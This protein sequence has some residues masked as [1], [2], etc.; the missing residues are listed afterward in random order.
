MEEGRQALLR[1][2]SVPGAGCQVCPD[3]ALQELRLGTGTRSTSPWGHTCRCPRAV[4]SGICTG[5]FLQLHPEQRGVDSV[6][7][8]G[9]VAAGPGGPAP[10]S[11]PAGLRAVRFPFETF[12]SSTTVDLLLSGVQ[13]VVG[14]LCASRRDP[15]AGPVPTCP[16]HGHPTVTRSVPRAGFHTP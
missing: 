5:G 15:P 14:H 11:D 2:S 7:R 10:R 9:R 4:G 16:V 13:L 1:L 3:P 8:V 6:G 12:I